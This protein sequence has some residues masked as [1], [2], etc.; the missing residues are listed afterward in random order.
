MGIIMFDGFDLGDRATRWQP[1]KTPLADT[2]NTRFGVGRAHVFSYDNGISRA[3]T[4]KSEVWAGFALY[5]I[6]TNANLATDRILFM[7]NGGVTSQ[8]SIRWPTISTLG[9]YRGNTSLGTATVPEPIGSWVYL[10]T[11]FKVHATTGRAVVRVNG[12]TVIDYTGN[13]DNAGTGL[14]DT[15]RFAGQPDANTTFYVDDFYLLDNVDAT[16][17]QGAPFNTFLGDV[18][19]YELSPNGAGTDTQMAASSGA[20]WTCV[21]EKPYNATDYVQGTVGQRDTYAVEDFSTT[22]NILAVQAVA[23][24]KKTDAGALSLKTAI[25]SGGNLYTG[26]TTVLGA[27]DATIATIHGVNPAT[28]AAWTVA[29]VNAAEVGAEV[30]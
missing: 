17:T 3:F 8:L 25:R 10:E 12:A 1:W 20:N 28:S 2:T 7:T 24:A 22:G 19:V 18:R 23:I 6:A 29:G 27:S 16:A 9:A 21:D 13:T 30:V 11:Y 4:A 5:Q 14:V 15:V 26:A